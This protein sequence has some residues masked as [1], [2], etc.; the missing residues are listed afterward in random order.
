[1]LTQWVLGRVR[2]LCPDGHTNGCPVKA[3]LHLL[4]QLCQDLRQGLLWGLREQPYLEK[5]LPQPGALSDFSLATG[6]T[7]EGTD[8]KHMQP[9]GGEQGLASH[10]A[11]QTQGPQGMRQ[12]VS[13]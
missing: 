7:Q 8:P 9:Q 13:D 1:M 12:W 6:W 3:F 10:P 5:H 11:K 2:P 4:P